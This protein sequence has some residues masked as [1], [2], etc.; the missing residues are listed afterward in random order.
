MSN[1]K[2]LAAAISIIMVVAFAFTM[3]GCGGGG[4][5]SGVV[6]AFFDSID[7]HDVKKFLNCFEEDIYEDILSYIGEDYLKDTLEMMDE[8]F[9]DEFGKNWRKQVKV[10]KAE[11]I[12]KDG[13]ITYYE[14]EVTLDGETEYIQVVKIK[15]K[16]YIDDGA[17]GGIF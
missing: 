9:S 17:M 1:K 2:R 5:A 12:D 7:K 14:V 8:I 4:G 11:E 13:S 15:G 6:N 3:T 10:G 16:Y